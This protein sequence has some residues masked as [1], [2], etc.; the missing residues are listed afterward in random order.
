MRSSAIQQHDQES[1]RVINFNCQIGVCYRCFPAID[2]TRW[3]NGQLDKVHNVKSVGQAIDKEQDI[4]LGVSQS[5]AGCA[6]HSTAT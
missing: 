2:W 1:Q 4:N 5:N 3:D 6:A